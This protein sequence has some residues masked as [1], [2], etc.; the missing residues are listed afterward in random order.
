MKVT[1]RRVEVGMNPG[2]MGASR[3]YRRDDIPSDTRLAAG[4]V[5]RVWAFARP[6]R[7]QIAAFLAVIGISAV[8][9][10]ATPL[11]V[12]SLIDTAIPQRDFGLINLIALGAV[13]IALLDAVFNVT[14]RW[15]TARVGEGLIFDLRAALFD[16]VQRQPLAF[17]THTQTGALVSRLNNDV[18]GA[19]RA[20]TG[21]L[22]SV[23]SDVVV[24]GS[25]LGVM[26]GLEWRLTLLALALLPVFILPSRRVGR[27][28][29]RL[30][31]EQMRLVASMN[32]T[33][34][35]R[36]NV[37]GALLVALFGRRAAEQADF[38]ERAGKV[39]DIGVRS[40]LYGRV[41]FVA[42]GLVG[43]LGTA[44]VYWLG[45]RLVLAGV[46]TTGTI[47]A[48]AAYLGRV[49]MP[50]INLTSA[51]IDVMT[52]FVSF[53]RV[54]EVLDHKPA[55]ADRP[56]AVDLAV[57]SGARG[58]AI[59]FD[60]VD[61]TYPEA[62][63][64]TLA[65]LA[66]ASA[67]E[68]PG[69]PGEQVLTDVTFDVEP[70]ELVALVG[71]SGAG[72]S[73][74]VSLVARLYEATAGTVRVGG[75][76]VR[77][78]TVDSLRRAIGVVTQ[79]PHLFHD[80]VMANLRYAKPGATVEEVEAASRA[81]RIHDLIASLPDGYDTVVGERGYRLSG[82]EKQ[83]LAIAR[84]LLANPAIVVLDEA[85]AHLDSESEAAIQAALDEALHGRTSLVIAHRLST[86]VRADRILVVSDGCIAEQGSHADLLGAGGRY[87]RLYE[88]QYG[89]GATQAEPAR[90]RPA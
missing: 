1:G 52:A 46:L 89:D 45:A 20:L 19:Q 55:I 10:A 14:Q 7:R 34:N 62:S 47:V 13:S 78:L 4:T 56:G 88:I 17:F 44:V 38:T 42:L 67:S 87:A 60:H 50:L 59:Q 73:T 22:G 76:D 90:L 37:A 29:Q 32:T 51:R 25:T 49:Y 77:D 68:L 80:T 43:A 66:E 39:R 61:F 12:R 57:S 6:Y 58:L 54:F 23:T 27:M 74:I 83:R 64:A 65:S 15:L 8:L 53:E 24:L 41:F 81:A 85:T 5:K 16:H 21:T 63:D 30:T 79:D 69:R 36:F 11:L 31:R 70:G 71:P 86:I 84:V 35:E 75:H 33:L 82:G 40:A 26:I 2:A 28:L 3:W 72:K 18:V 48:F 9:G